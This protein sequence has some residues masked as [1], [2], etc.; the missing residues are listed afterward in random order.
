[1][2]KAARLI[3]LCLGLA[4][5]YHLLRE[6]GESVR[7]SLSRVGWRVIPYLGATLLV[8]TLD[9]WGWRLAFL[10]GQ[11]PAPFVALFNI[12]MAGES[13]NK[14]TPLASL[15]GEP[16]KAYLLTRHGSTAA[17]A[18]SS[19]FISKNTITLAQVTFI[20]LGIAV[21]WSLLPGKG[22]VLLGFG[23]FPSLVLGAMLV[24]AV[25]DLRLR[26][27][28]KRQGGEGERVP[29]ALA[30]WGKVADYFWSNP[31]GFALSTLLFFLG[32]AAGTLEQLA[33]AYALGFHL[34]LAEAFAIEA[35]LISVN[36]AT[37]FIPVNVG[38]QE[39]AFAFIAPLFGLSSA[40]GLALAVLR[41]VRDV[42]WILY[43]LAYVGLTEGRIVFKPDE[44]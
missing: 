13:V 43:G 28:K 2:L 7:E 41:R 12:R 42:V 10:D 24:A 32:W 20:Y 19:V 35:L 31:R 29:P 6:H 9:T 3:L 33:A 34:T 26:R 44:E 8:Y 36:M 27:R 4:V 5:A 17:D 40:T 15:G 39:G 30:L 37:F 25:L 16:L 18:G 21:A 11:P 1:M 22:R 38:T 23:V 14:V